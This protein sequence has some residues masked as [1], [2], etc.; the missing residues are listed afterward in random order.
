MGVL[1]SSFGPTQLSIGGF[2]VPLEVATPVCE[3]GGGNKS[4]KALLSVVGPDGESTEGMIC[5][6]AVEDVVSRQ[7]TT[8][9]SLVVVVYY[10]ST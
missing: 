4:L 2:Q 9:N 3:G 1:G 8:P 5:A 10:C 6:Q 7:T